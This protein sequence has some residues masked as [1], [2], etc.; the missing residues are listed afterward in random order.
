LKLSDLIKTGENKAQGAGYTVCGEKKAQ[1]ARPTAHGE[2]GTQSVRHGAEGQSDM[3]IASIHYRAQEVLPGGL[4][5]AIKGQAADGHDYV[6]TAL[7]RGASAVVAQRK[8]DL[9]PGSATVLVRVPDTRRALADLAARFYHNPSEHLVLVGITGT[10][11]KTTTSYLVESMLIQAGLS[12]G[13]IGTINYRHGGRTFTNPV[14]T[15]E[16]ADLQRILAEMRLQG[17]SHV[18]LEVSSHAIELHRIQNC[19]FDVAVFT[20]L[21]QDHLNF[22]GDMAAY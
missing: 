6:Q 3:E 15:P 5:V 8:V 20:N 12:V 16:S 17:V 19:W 21:T 10:N 11:G 14:T 22:H 1:G 13:V 7:E 4:F 18:I 2:S 9:S